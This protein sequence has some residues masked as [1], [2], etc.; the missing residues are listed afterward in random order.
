MTATAMN[1]KYPDFF[2][3]SY[4]V[5]GKWGA[6]LVTPMA[7]NK[8]WWMASEDDLGAFPSFN[9]ITERLQ[10]QGVKISRAVWDG[11]WNADQY[12][13]AYDDFGAGQARLLELADVPAHFVKFDM[14]LIRG[15]HN[16]SPRKRQLVRDLVQMVL[17][18]GSIP[19]AEGV[20]DAATLHRLQGFGC[21][22]GQ[23]FHWSPALPA[24]GFCALVRNHQDS[25][26]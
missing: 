1:I 22:F 6:D 23:G 17:A 5:A 26:A 11:K 21:E 3:A 24:E 25:A 16:A 14:S 8:V 10:Q 15:L 4:L 7:K 13:F 20:E 19:L 2:A 9:A 18:T 12:R